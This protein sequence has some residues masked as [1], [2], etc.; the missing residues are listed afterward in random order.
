MKTRQAL[1]QAADK[2]ERYQF[3][4]VIRRE[5][6][7]KGMWIVDGDLSRISTWIFDGKLLDE[8]AAEFD[9]KGISLADHLQANNTVVY[10][11]DGTEPTVTYH[12]CTKQAIS[13]LRKIESKLAMWHERCQAAYGALCE[14]S[15]AWVLGQVT[16]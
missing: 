11:V 14:Y 16:A 8:V 10:H 6:L 12:V 1:E 13:R 4:W 9:E 2:A 15:K 5:E 7:L 3:Y